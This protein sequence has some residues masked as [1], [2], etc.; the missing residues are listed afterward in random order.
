MAL[1]LSEFELEALPE[2]EFEL[3]NEFEGELEGEMESH[4]L[5]E[6]ELHEGEI[7]PVRKYYVDAMLEHMGEVAAEAETEQEAAEGFLPLIPMLAAK[8]LPLAA[9]FGA[10]MLPKIA[11]KVLPR[12]AKMF[13]RVTPRL[14]RGVTRITRGLHRNPRTR[15]LVRAVPTIARRTVATIAKRAATGRPVTPRLANRVLVAQ[16]RRVL[17]SPQ[18]TARILRRSRTL[19]RHIHRVNGPA[20]APHMRHTGYAYGGGGGGG[21]S[22]GKCICPT[23]GQA[24]AAPVVMQA[25]VMQAPVMPAPVMTTPVMAA[26]PAAIC[27]RCARAMR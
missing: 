12:V 17:R 4:E 11:G 21:Y 22:Y 2:L 13:N 27:A 6:L 25:P 26:P 3:E 19:D 24:A 23:P 9:K 7:S 14:T 20:V 5:H 1:A 15:P 8:A 10:K 18:Q 16:T